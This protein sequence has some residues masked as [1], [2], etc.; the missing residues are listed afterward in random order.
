MKDNERVLIVEDSK[1]AL[2]IIQ[3]LLANEGYDV[4]TASSGL[5]AYE[6][7][8]KDS[9]FLSLILDWI[10]P[11]M[12]GLELL[13]RVKANAKWKQI[14]VI[15]QTSKSDKHSIIQGIN[16]GAYYYL[17]KPYSKKVLLAIL[18]STISEYKRNL[19]ILHKEIGDSYSILN[20]LEEGSIVFSTIAEGDIIAR[21]LSRFAVNPSTA[22]GFEELF[23]NSIEH[24]NL[25]ICYK[26]KANLLEENRLEKEIQKRAKIPENARKT[27]EVQFKKTGR[28]MKVHIKDQGEGFDFKKYLEFSPERIFDLNGRGIAMVNKEIFQGLRYIGNGSQVLVRFA[29]TE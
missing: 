19:D 9:Q 10:M 28:F 2:Q 8:Q 4:V 20:F 21:W 23:V 5:E 11:D 13:K 17:T 25:G 14:P 1:L 12:D 7:L 26:E 6:L 18:K 24:G 16:A 15:M 27:V 22:I 3:D 29:L